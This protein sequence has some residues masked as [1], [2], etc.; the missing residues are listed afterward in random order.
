MFLYIY[1][2]VPVTRTENASPSASTVHFE[3]QTPHQQ[4]KFQYWV[5]STIIDINQPLNI[6]D[7]NTEWTEEE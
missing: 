4:H 6:V 3:P 2:L 5:K 7:F 1:E